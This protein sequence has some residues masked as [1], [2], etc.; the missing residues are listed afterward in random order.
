[1]SPEAAYKGRP[2]VP[3]SARGRAVVVDAISFYGDV[4][5]ETGLLRD[6]RSI[7]GRILAARRSR[8]ST[9]GSY[10]IMALKYNSKAPAAIIME[11]AEPIV[12]VGAYLAGVPLVDS[13]PRGLF[14]S[15]RD[16]D[17]VVVEADGTVRIL[18]RPGA[19]G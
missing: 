8:G 18:R 6:G 4:D 3:G 17:E 11:R 1:M 15:L 13:L 14:E 9:V 12:V 2:L 7:A 16:G 5:P 10:V 19:G